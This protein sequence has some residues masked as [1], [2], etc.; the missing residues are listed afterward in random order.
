MFKKLLVFFS[1]FALILTLI[2]LFPVHLVQATTYF[3][4]NFE[5]GDISDWTP[6]NNS[7][8]SQWR[9]N[10]KAGNKRLGI[11]ISENCFTEI[12]P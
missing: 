12:A 8:G 9:I 4:D 2:L 6:T 5:D 3:S 10:E 7:C 1:R 11:V